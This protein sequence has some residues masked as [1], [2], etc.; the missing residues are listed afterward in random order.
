MRRLARGLSSGAVRRPLRPD[1]H[2]HC[3][4]AERK[5]SGASGR[6]NT[7]NHFELKSAST[8]PYRMP[9]MRLALMPVPCSRSLGIRYA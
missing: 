1:I 2:S 3:K 9:G 5:R 6:R 7:S 4:V 8:G